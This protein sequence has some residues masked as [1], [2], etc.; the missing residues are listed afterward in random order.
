MT[1]TDPTPV[2]AVALLTPCGYCGA[3]PDVWCRTRGGHRYE[4]LHAVRDRPV[5]RL[6]SREYRE[7]MIDAWSEVRS[8]ITSGDY[9]GRPPANLTELLS[10]V[11]G[12]LTAWE[13]L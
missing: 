5:Q 8:I 12:R 10:W 6:S 7:G 13:K 1:Y 4:Y 9:R 3:A 11:N 2:Q